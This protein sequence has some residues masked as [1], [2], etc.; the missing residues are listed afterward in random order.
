MSQVEKTMNMCIQLIF[1][2]QF[3][4]CTITVI[5]WVVWTRIFSGDYPYLYSSSVQVRYPSTSFLCPVI[6]CPILLVCGSLTPGPFAQLWI[7]DWLG[8][9]FTFLLLFNNFIPI[10]LYVTVEM[11]NYVQAFLINQDAEMYDPESDTPARAR[12]SNLNQD[13]GQI[14]YVFSDKTGTLTR[15]VME[16]KQCSV[17]GR[18]FGT[19]TPEGDANAS[20]ADVNGEKSLA[21]HQADLTTTLWGSFLCYCRRKPAAGGGSSWWSPQHAPVKPQLPS[22]ARTAGV[23]RLSLTAPATRPMSPTTSGFTDEMLLRVLRGGPS[24]GYVTPQQLEALERFFMCMAVCHTVV[25]E[26]DPNGGPP[27]YQAE[28]P[29]EGALTKA[30]RDVGFEFVARHADHIIVNR[31]TG[32]AQPTPTRCA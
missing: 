30:A 8:N 28:S 12:T 15:N 27:V 13:I 6:A 10:S 5:A 26:A 19:F 16:F 22:A 18:V 3:L 20:A 14:E 9:W 31:V 23:P 29:D 4:L 11:V 21:E 7:P 2:A 25:P 17:A 24:R 32:N 1:L